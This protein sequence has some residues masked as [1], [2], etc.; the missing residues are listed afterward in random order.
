MT[1]LE[2]LQAELERT[3]LLVARIVDEVTNVKFLI[4]E[5]QGQIK[6]PDIPSTVVDTLTAINAQL[7]NIANELPSVPGSANG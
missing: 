2:S 5:L 1:A 6:S 3:R 7:T 4:A